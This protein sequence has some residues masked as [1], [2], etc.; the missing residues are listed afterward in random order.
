ML[1]V[2]DEMDIDLEAGLAAVAVW[3]IT[4][5]PVKKI[6]LGAHA[7]VHIKSDKL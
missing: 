5:W 1:S 4:A 6:N 7:L 2:M 3:V